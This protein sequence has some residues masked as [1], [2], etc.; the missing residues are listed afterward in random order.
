MVD[1]IFAVSHTGCVHECASTST[2]LCAAGPSVPTAQSSPFRPTR[3]NVTM[4]F[5]SAPTS[6]L[7]VTRTV[8]SAVDGYGGVATT[9][10]PACT[11]QSA[12]VSSAEPSDCAPPPAVIWPFRRLWRGCVHCTLSK[13]MSTLSMIHRSPPRGIR[14]T[15]RTSA[16]QKPHNA[17][18]IISSPWRAPDVVAA[19][20]RVPVVDS[21]YTSVAVAVCAPGVPDVV[22]LATS[23]HSEYQST[24]TRLT[25][26]AVP[27]VGTPHSAKPLAVSTSSFA[28]YHASAPAGST[29]TYAASARLYA[30]TLVR[31]LTSP[32]V[33]GTKLSTTHRSTPP[34]LYST[35]LCRT[36]LVWP[37]TSAPVVIRIRVVAPTDNGHNDTIRSS[38]ATAPHL[39]GTMAL[40]MPLHVFW[41]C[42]ERRYP[43]VGCVGIKDQCRVSEV[44][45]TLN[46]LCEGMRLLGVMVWCVG[47]ETLL[48][49]K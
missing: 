44:W 38:A 6:S 16:P 30:H 11:S 18:T 48:Y 47:R 39:Q 40:R 14:R 19:R 15:P 4:S 17:A 9:T 26:E 37:V 23:V 25:H 7:T 29:R 35:T 43:E 42:S 21:K 10:A 33:L 46:A 13:R 2:A 12:A 3:A 1:V 32:I 41:C 49:I 20:Q 36:R 8:P 24:A 27:T 28:M 22:T 5:E 34:A 31:V 45:L